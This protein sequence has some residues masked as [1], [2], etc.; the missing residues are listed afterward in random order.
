MASSVQFFVTVKV[1][2]HGEWVPPNFGQKPL[3]MYLGNIHY[4]QN[5]FFGG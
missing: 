4:T 3:K 2:E 1:Q 5:P